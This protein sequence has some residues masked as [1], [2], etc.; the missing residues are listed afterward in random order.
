MKLQWTMAGDPWSAS[1]ASAL[2]VRNLA[3][4]S[5][6]SITVLFCHS[7]NWSWVTIR[8]SPAW[9]NHVT[10]IISIMQIAVD[11]SF[12]YE[13]RVI[14]TAEWFRHRSPYQLLYGSTSFVNVIFLHIFFYC[15]ILFSNV[16][17]FLFNVDFLG[18]GIEN[19]KQYIN[20]IVLCWRDSKCFSFL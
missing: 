7:M 13:P 1:L 15:H 14:L 12:Y 6:T 9:N 5:A 20:S 17:S 10:N 16:S 19:S 8:V 2:T 3:W 4:N 18:W 11:D